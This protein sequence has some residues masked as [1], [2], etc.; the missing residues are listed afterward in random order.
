MFFKYSK[1]LNLSV[2]SIIGA[3]FNQ[4]RNHIIIWGPILRDMVNISIREQYIHSQITAISL[5]D[6]DEYPPFLGGIQFSLT[7]ADN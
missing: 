3:S 7:N 4:F 6:D 2:Q 5:S 1:P